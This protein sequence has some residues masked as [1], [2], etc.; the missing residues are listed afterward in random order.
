LS[1]HEP[2]QALLGALILITKYIIQNGKGRVRKFKR[3]FGVT[4]NWKYDAVKVRYSSL[5]VKKMF[6]HFP[7]Q[8]F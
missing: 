4:E 7:V 5:L 6:L 1:I 3:Y 2:K 8:D